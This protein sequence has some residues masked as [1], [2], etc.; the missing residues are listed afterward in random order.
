MRTIRWL[1]LAVALGAAGSSANA[2][3]PERYATGLQVD[4][5]T[6]RGNDA[7]YQPGDTMLVQTHLSDD[8][9]LLV[10]EIDAEGTVNVLFPERG[11]SGFV[12]GGTTVDIP[13]EHSNL[14]LVV[15]PETG[16]SFIVAIA[17]REP[18]QDLPWYLR[19]YDP[20]A[21]GNGYAGEPD[22]EDGITKDGRI[23]GDP[24]VAM[25]RIRR[26]VLQHPDDPESFGTAYTS[27]YTHEKVLYP[28]YLCNDCHRPDYYAWWDGF[29]PYYAQCP[30]VE[31]R[32]NWGWYW[33][34][35]YWFG[36]VPY[37][38][39][40]VRP[41]CPP[42]WRMYSAH[43]WYSSWNCW[44]QWHERMGSGGQRPPA[45][46][47]PSAR[48]IDP[49]QRPRTGGPG[50]MASRT[51][52]MGRHGPWRSIT[53]AFRPS[54]RPEDRRVALGSRDPWHGRI[55]PR[56]PGRPRRDDSETRGWSRGIPEGRRGG[57]RW[58][59][60]GSGAAPRP[61]EVRT[62]IGRGRQAEALPQ[63]LEWSGER[64]APPPREFRGEGTRIHFGNERRESRPQE[65]PPP[66]PARAPSVG[67]GN[68][69]SGQDGNGN[70]SGNAHPISSS[71]GRAG[72]KPGH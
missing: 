51:P 39:Y 13:S 30:V 20:Q 48:R 61:V 37:Y 6:D 5:W 17:S 57:F 63:R 2:Q 8:G 42:Q 49:M 27:Y 12:E 18:F 60:P 7:V 16:E 72:G 58:V 21:E 54:G 4:V 35:S 31:F 59:G 43:R 34:P 44:G 66:E 45:D 68:S 22:D 26:R 62:P 29:D 23:V 55:Q 9:N 46:Y 70:N 52:A 71:F 11:S 50:L 24:F 15:E 40:A 67:R 36:S 65:A 32:V 64:T 10:Y 38:Y 69:G 47:I 33:G 53:E 1:W 3:E 25:E 19:P 14:Q 28:R 41:D 56:D